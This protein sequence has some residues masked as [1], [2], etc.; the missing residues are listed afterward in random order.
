MSSPFTHRAN[1]APLREDFQESRHIEAHVHLRMFAEGAVF[2]GA[3]VVSVRGAPQRVEWKS[4]FYPGPRLRGGGQAD[5][6]ARMLPL[7]FHEG[8]DLYL[9]RWPDVSASIVARSVDGDASSRDAAAWAKPAVA[10]ALRE[11]VRRARLLAAGPAQG[12]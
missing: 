9:R 12:R 6:G 10:C 2:V 11:G 7:G 5:D 4:A 1:A 8:F 3:R